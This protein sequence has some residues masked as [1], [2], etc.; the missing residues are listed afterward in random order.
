MRKQVLYEVGSNA[1]LDGDVLMDASRSFYMP[2]GPFVMNGEVR[3]R[4][5]SNSMHDH[6]TA[7]SYRTVS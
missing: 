4:G 6:H 2:D 7:S 5:T 1:Q 3:Q